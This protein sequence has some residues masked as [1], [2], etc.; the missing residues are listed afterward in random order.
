MSAERCCYLFASFTLSRCFSH[1]FLNLRKLFCCLKLTN[2]FTT[3]T[4]FYSKF[5]EARHEAERKCI[6]EAFRD[7]VSHSVLGF[8]EMYHAEIGL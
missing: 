6:H 8:V 2:C 3:L 7:V 1:L 5:I 4:R